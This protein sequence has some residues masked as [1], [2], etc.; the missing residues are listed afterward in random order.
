[1]TLKKTITIVITSVA[2]LILMFSIVI[3]FM[4]SRAIQ[5]NEPL[6]MFGYS[7]TVVAPTGSMLGD[8]PD[9]L[10]NYDIAIIRRGSFEEIQIGMVIVF[11]AEYNTNDKVLVIHRVIGLHPDGGYETKGDNNASVDQEPVTEDNFQGIYVSKI[12]FLRPVSELAANGKNIIFL[13]LI[14]VLATLLISEVMNIIKQVN[15]SKKDQ[16]LEQT[17][18]EI[19]A[20]KA[21]EKEKIYQE[22]LEE[23]RK[24]KLPKNE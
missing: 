19:E 16:L 1:M 2:L 8:L 7:F 10:D 5:K 20:M 17:A 23:E 3:M 13:V 9:S 14:I 4:G 6:Y 18:L 11:Q 12:T 21:L 22:I 15:H 24:K